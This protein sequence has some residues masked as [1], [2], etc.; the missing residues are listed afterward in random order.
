MEF[1]R[2]SDDEMRLIVLF[3]SLASEVERNETLHKL[4]VRLFGR[5]FPDTTVYDFMP[6][7]AGIEPSSSRFD[8]WTLSYVL[9]CAIEETGCPLE[10]LFGSSCWDEEQAIP[11]FIYG[12]QSA[13]AK[14]G[15]FFVHYDEDFAREYISEWRWELLDAISL[16]SSEVK[17]GQ[18]QSNDG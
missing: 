8:T 6:E 3:R 1:P 11:R 9:Y 5:H 7:A 12:A 17:K 4:G 15:G 14:H 2:L 10:T 18:E 16:K 13:A